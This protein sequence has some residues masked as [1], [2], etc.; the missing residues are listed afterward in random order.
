M[1]PSFFVKSHTIL[2]RYNVFSPDEDGLGDIQAKLDETLGQANSPSQV[3][4]TSVLPDRLHGVFN[5]KQGRAQRL[6]G[7]PQTSVKE[8]IAR[9]NGTAQNPID[10]TSANGPAAAQNPLEMLKAVPV[11]FLKF[12]EDVRPPYIG[13]YTKSPEGRSA[14]SL[15]RNPFSRTLPATNYD[16]D[17]EAEWEEPEEGE[18]LDSEGEEEEEEDDDANDM[19]GFLDDGNTEEVKKTR[20]IIGN[21]EPNCTGLCWEDSHSRICRTGSTDPPLDLSPYRI[22]LLLGKSY[23]YQHGSLYQD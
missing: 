2:A 19:E 21:L 9:L 7:R 5:N 16:Y 20:P 3:D 8:I 12:Y 18:D 10:L 22:E 14:A 23:P 4:S 11:K 1:F 6:R 15:G 17:S 13:T